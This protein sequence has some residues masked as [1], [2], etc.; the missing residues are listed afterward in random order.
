VDISGGIQAS[1]AGRYAI[2]LFELAGEQK[3]LDAVGESLA[4]LKQAL[5]ES[6]DFRALT[7]SPLVGRDQAERAADG[8]PRR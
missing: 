2:A 4:R 8:H 3:Q 5:A 6:D 1:L 7:T